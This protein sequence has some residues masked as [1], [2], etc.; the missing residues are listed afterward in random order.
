MNEFVDPDQDS[1][2]LVTKEK[3]HLIFDQMMSEW[4]DEVIET[5]I[6]VTPQLKPMSQFRLKLME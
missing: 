3:V 6:E 4:K 5:R 2:C 1:D